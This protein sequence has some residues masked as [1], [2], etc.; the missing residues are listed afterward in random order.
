MA[1]AGETPPVM[2]VNALKAIL[3]VIESLIQRVEYMEGHMTTLQGSMS[4]MDGKIFNL[5]GHIISTQSTPQNSHA[6]SSGHSQN[7]F[8]TISP[9]SLHLS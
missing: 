3:V 9:E 5:E 8:A 2:D 7:T 6:L 4:N 1:P